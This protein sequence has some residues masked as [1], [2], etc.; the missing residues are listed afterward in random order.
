MKIIKFLKSIKP[1][2]IIL[3]LFVIVLIVSALGSKT[4]EGMTSGNYTSLENYI[5]QRDDI[6]SDINNFIN[7]QDD[8]SPWGSSVD[9]LKNIINYFKIK[10]SFSVKQFFKNKDLNG[11]GAVVVRKSNGTF[12]RDN[13]TNNL[14]TDEKLYYYDLVA[15]DKN[16]DSTIVAFKDT[17]QGNF[18]KDN[19]DNSG[20]LTTSQSLSGTPHILQSID[21][22]DT[23]TQTK[24][25]QAKSLL[26]NQINL[27]NSSDK[28]TINTS[29]NN[30]GGVIDKIIA[31]VYENGGL[32]SDVDSSAYN[33]NYIE[34]TS[35]DQYQQDQYLK[36]LQNQI[37][38]LRED[39]Y[40]KNSN[41]Y[42]SKSADY[43]KNL[44][45]EFFKH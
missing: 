24:V 5:K 19:Q 21:R 3:V 31:L 42:D 36:N 23:V 33:P 40:K 37:I 9:F 28:N 20:N 2:Y 12:I 34:T 38:K 43:W 18:Y 39:Q 45:F 17:D 35:S 11:D 44:Y 4:K 15:Q 22:N 14:D 30:L 26:D 6:L 32:G 27:L 8:T 41:N 1:I 16:S 13:S 25:D 29:I 10:T 7:A